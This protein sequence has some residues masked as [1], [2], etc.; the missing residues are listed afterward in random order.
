MR[1]RKK[2]GKKLLVVAAENKMRKAW[3]KI[4]TF[5]SITYKKKLKGF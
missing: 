3:S 5:K 1:K 2:K 4:T